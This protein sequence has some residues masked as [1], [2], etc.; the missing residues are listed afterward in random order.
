MLNQYYFVYF[1]T[2]IFSMLF[3]RCFPCISR[4]RS[5]IY[6]CRGDIQTGAWN[7][8]VHRSIFWIILQCSKSAFFLLVHCIYFLVA[9]HYTM[10]PR[11]LDLKSV[12][13][14]KIQYKP[15]RI[16]K[17]PLGTC[18]RKVEEEKFPCVTRCSRPWGNC[19]FSLELEQRAINNSTGCLD[20]ITL[21]EIY[22][23]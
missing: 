13:S 3:L 9:T 20:R 17:L 21:E 8:N 4:G 10:M 12:M 16:W 1:K 6:K 7:R 14:F 18:G 2:I 11:V 23:S 5:Y 22:R 15:K 19:L